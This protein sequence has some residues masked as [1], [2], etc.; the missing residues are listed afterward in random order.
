MNKPIILL[1]SMLTIF[2][3]ACNDGGSDNDDDVFDSG[4]AEDAGGELP[5]EPDA[6]PADSGT[7]PPP[8]GPSTVYH[9]TFDPLGGSFS[10]PLNVTLE[11]LTEAASIFYTTDGS[12]P[13]CAGTGGLAPQLVEIVA[14]TTLKAIA[15][16]TNMDDSAISQ[17]IYAAIAPPG[18]SAV[19]LMKT[20][21]KSR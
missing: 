21:S 5:P 2:M 3:F 20:A 11:T 9:P 16:K 13:M 4:S 14:E 6:G 1:I 18:S 7:T 15:C 17:A 19:Q 8:P 12:D 10:L